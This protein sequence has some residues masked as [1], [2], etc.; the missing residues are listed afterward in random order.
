MLRSHVSPVSLKTMSRSPDNE[1]GC[2]VA[3]DT[4]D[5]GAEAAVMTKAEEAKMMG[6]GHQEGKMDTGA[7]GEGR[8]MGELPE[9]VLEHILSFLSPYQEHKIAA[10]VCKQWYRL[11]KG[12][13]KLKIQGEFSDAQT[14][15]SAL[16]YKPYSAVVSSLGVAYQCYHGFLKAIKEGNIQWESRTYPYPGTP[17]TQRFSHSKYQAA[18]HHIVFTPINK[19]NQT[20]RR[21]SSDLTAPVS[22]L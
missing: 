12:T 15:L 21:S 4:E 5:D 20:F 6:S 1:E 9:E 17:I 3:M 16:L 22:C 11:I 8:S 2:F 10:L 14:N 13:W 19:K 7:K 18:S